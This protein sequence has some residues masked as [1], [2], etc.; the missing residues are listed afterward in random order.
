MK[1]RYEERKQKERK[2]LI[3][4]SIMGDASTHEKWKKELVN[5]RREERKKIKL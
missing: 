5:R 1:P 3:S 4:R 2:T